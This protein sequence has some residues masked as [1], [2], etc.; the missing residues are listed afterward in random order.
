MK[1]GRLV[2][3]YGTPGNDRQPQAMVQFLANWIDFGLDLQQAVE[4][5]RV[6]SYSFPATGHPHLYEPGKLR[7]EPELPAGVLADLAARGHDVEASGDHSFEGFGSVC[8]IRVDQ[9]RGILIGAADP[10]RTA[11]AIG[12]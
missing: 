11:Y 5:P 9:E 3:P 4:S 10:R 2:M 8:A 1:D 12:W 7:A 6:A